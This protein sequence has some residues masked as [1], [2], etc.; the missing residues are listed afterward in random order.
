MAK[1]LFPPLLTGPLPFINRPIF[2]YREGAIKMQI[3]EI[4]P[5]VNKES[6]LQTD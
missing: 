5:K 3:S 2:E 6:L 4:H 1:Q